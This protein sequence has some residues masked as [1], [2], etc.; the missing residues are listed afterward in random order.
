MD[1]RRYARHPADVPI[2]IATLG[3]CD[4]PLGEE[5]LSDIGLG[6]LAFESES[7]LDEGALLVISMP[8]VIP[9]F[10]IRGRVVWCRQNDGRF[11]VGVE[12]TE[13]EKQFRARMVEQICQIEHY[14]NEVLV[15]E[16]RNLSGE[17]AAREW[18]EK[19]AAK[20]PE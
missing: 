8:S 1:K 20:F 9:A 11:D 3:A 7:A 2:Q 12:F 4:P 18:I 16:G 17:E 19:H 13:P 10:Q 15:N 6:G 14:R 5:R